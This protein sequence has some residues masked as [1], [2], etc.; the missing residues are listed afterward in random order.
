MRMRAELDGVRGECEIRVCGEARVVA[1]GETQCDAIERWKTRGR[2]ERMMHAADGECEAAWRSPARAQGART[3]ERK[4][5]QQP[6]VDEQRIDRD[7]A[8]IEVEDADRIEIEPQQIVV[9]ARQDRGH[10]TSTTKRLRP[11]S[12]M[13]RSRFASMSVGMPQRSCTIRPNR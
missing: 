8:L 4:T 7:R 9:H 3:R 5:M 13:I 2:R 1:C 11:P 6:R 10:P 12:S